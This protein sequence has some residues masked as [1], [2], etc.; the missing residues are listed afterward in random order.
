METKTTHW[1]LKVNKTT[2]QF[3][4]HLCDAK[5]TSPT[6]SL[7][8]K[9]PRKV[10]SCLVVVNISWRHFVFVAA[11]ILEKVGKP[12]IKLQMVWTTREQPWDVT[13]THQSSRP[14]TRLI[15]SQ[16]VFHWQIMD[17]NLTQNMHKYLSI[18]GESTDTTD[19]PA[20]KQNGSVGV[21]WTWL[22]SAEVAARLSCRSRSDRSGSRQ[23]RA[24]FCWRAEL[25]LPA[26]HHAALRLPGIRGLWI[27][28]ARWL[29]ACVSTVSWWFS[30]ELQDLFRVLFW[31][32][33]SFFFLAFI[34]L[35]LVLCVKLCETSVELHS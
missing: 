22:Q 17:G 10:P 20:K 18:I 15:F 33:F 12:N 14:E 2:K 31:F 3:H 8:F 13:E 35:F 23:E 27:Q 26:G 11:A 5:V 9:P 32:W 34:C 1:V 30:K 28:A 21:I 6:S 24:W 19:Q 7:L 16:D 29:T 4:V 25:P